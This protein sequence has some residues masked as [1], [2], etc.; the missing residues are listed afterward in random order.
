MKD[1][2]PGFLRF[3]ILLSAFFA[4][5]PIILQKFGMDIYYREGLAWC[6]IFPHEIVLLTAYVPIFTS[7]FCTLFFVLMTLRV[8]KKRD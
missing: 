1:R 5:L 7:G 8:L 3:N 2:F 6:S 4:S